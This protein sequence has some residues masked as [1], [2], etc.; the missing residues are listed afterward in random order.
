MISVGFTSNRDETFYA[1]EKTL[2]GSY[3]LYDL[4]AL[5]FFK[6]HANYVTKE[7]LAH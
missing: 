1:K 3:G 7:S 5:N 4:D 2:I 6:C